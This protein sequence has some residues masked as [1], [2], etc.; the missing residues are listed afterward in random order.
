MLRYMLIKRSE[1][2]TCNG[3]KLKELY[4]LSLFFV[5]AV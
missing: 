4:L 3:S 1:D 5:V 2:S